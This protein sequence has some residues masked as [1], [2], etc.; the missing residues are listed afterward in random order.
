MKTQRRR[1]AKTFLKKTN[2]MRE[3]DLTVTKPDF[4]DNV[5]TTYTT[6]QIKTAQY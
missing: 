5:V 6:I 1:R 4:K 3:L 2:E